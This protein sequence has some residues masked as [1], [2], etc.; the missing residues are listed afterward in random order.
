MNEADSYSASGL[1]ELFVCISIYINE[2]S[3]ELRMFLMQ[4]RPD[5]DYPFNS[6]DQANDTVTGKI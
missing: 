4:D 1:T 5:A 2:S 3:D 6:I